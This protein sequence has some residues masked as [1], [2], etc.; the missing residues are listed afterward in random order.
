MS[1]CDGGGGG[2][3][4]DTL[5][6]AANIEVV[7]DDG[8][9]NK[10]ASSWDGSSSVDDSGR[11]D[12]LVERKED[13]VRD[14]SL[15]NESVT[16]ADLSWGTWASQV[17]DT[18][19][20]GG[21]L[22]EDVSAVAGRLVDTS[23]ASVARCQAGLDGLGSRVADE[24][25]AG[26]LGSGAEASIVLPKLAINGEL[27]ANGWSSEGAVGVCSGGGVASEESQNGDGSLSEHDD[28]L[29]D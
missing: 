10:L 6:A 14:L 20:D 19:A 27:G 17:A 12:L 8:N 13:G 29:V 3:Q 25:E 9:L 26:E 23:K 2:G 7:V 16:T 21:G 24:S 15:G 11:S 4:G 22:I 5:S 1:V 18:G 28:G